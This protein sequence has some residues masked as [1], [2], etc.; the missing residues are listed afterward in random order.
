MIDEYSGLMITRLRKTILEQCGPMSQ[1]RLADSL[2]INRGRLSRYATG[3]QVI[4]AHHMLL[5]AEA[6]HCNP[7][8]LIGYCDVDSA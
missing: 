4:P 7:Q 6:L 2:G 5:L 1:N 8:D 3:T